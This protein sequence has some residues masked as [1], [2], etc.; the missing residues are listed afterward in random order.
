MSL[1]AASQAP[2]L[3]QSLE[4]SI[5][6]RGF[7]QDAAFAQQRGSGLSI[8]AEPEFD[9][10]LGQ[11]SS[12]RLVPF[13][14]WDQRDDERTHVDIREFALRV[15]HGSLDVVAGISRVF[16]GVT[17]SVHL[18]DIVNQTDLVENPDGEDK[19]GQPMF[20]FMWS[21]RYGNLAGFVL[22]YFRE[23]TLPGI[24][25]RLRAPLPYDQ[26]T[27]LY[28]SGAEANHVDGALR[29]T[30]ST[31]ALDLGVSHFSGTARDPRFVVRDTSRGAVLTPVYDLI[32]RSGVDINWVSGSW[33][34]KLEAI[35]QS[36]RIDDYAAAAG[37][38]EYTYSGAFGTAWDAGVLME[39]LW[40]ERGEEGPA[41]FQNDVFVGTRWSGNDVEGTELLAGAA[42]DLD[43]HGLFA[44]IEASRRLGESG[45]LVFELR[46]FDGGAESDPLE[47]FARDD[48]VQLEYTHYW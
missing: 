6:A 16:W 31:G 1:P 42:I 19:L 11:S 17:E 32:E 45:K 20:N 36:D 22:P 30:L 48:Y 18:V 14:R 23:R 46:V 3:K 2:E 29:Y 25:G 41:A 7:T 13:G 33:L 21:T 47:A 43:H 27:V 26:R 24:E 35:R 4:V 12:I 9:Y 37:G 10:A 5:E 39:L 40:D 38:F 44:T 34:W 8:S 15:R 28:E